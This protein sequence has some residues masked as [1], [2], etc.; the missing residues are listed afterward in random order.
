MTKTS[1][2]R[3]IEALWLGRYG[4]MAMDLVRDS[5]ITKNPEDEAAYIQ[6][7]IALALIAIVR[8]IRMEPGR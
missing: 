5:E 3:R 2:N 7:A 1:D 8:E 6:R 4:Q